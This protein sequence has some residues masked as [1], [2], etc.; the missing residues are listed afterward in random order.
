VLPAPEAPPLLPLAP[1]PVVDPLPA[2]VLPPPVVL[3]APAP[4]DADVAPDPIV[5][6]ARIH[7]LLAPA[8]ALPLPAEPLVPAV[9]LADP[10][11]CRQPVT[12][13]VRLP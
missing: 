1:L 7:W 5:A 4:V 12:V 2:D 9:A 6:F 8:E 3:P 10:P 13:M 11:R